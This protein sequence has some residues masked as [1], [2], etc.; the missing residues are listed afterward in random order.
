M[1]LTFIGQKKGMMQLFDA[2]G[3]LVPC[4]IIAVEPNTIVRIKDQETEGYNAVQIGGIKMTKAQA[5]RANKPLRSYYAKQGVEPLRVLRESRVDDTASYQVGQTLDLSY[6]SDIQYVDVEGVTK[7]K[8]YQGVMK[9]HG[10]A[11]GPAAHG[12]GFHRK[13]GSTGM[14]STPGRCFPGGR[15]ASRMGGDQQTT[16]NLK[17]VAIHGN[18]LLV[19]G[20]VPG[21]PGAVIHVTA[22]KKRHQQ[23]TKRG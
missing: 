20:A 11:G 16:Q 14:R 21:A 4:T 12:S 5:F 17:V 7:G 8:G 15:R 22:S 10:M 23:K 9:L 2:E 18:L 13:H 3:K 6:F 19:K 1:S